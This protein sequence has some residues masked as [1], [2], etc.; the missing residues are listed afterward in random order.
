M[1]YIKGGRKQQAGYS[2][3]GGLTSRAP[4]FSGRLHLQMHDRGRL[5]LIL[6]DCFACADPDGAIAHLKEH[7]MYSLFCQVHILPLFVFENTSGDIAW[8]AS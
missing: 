6:M 3:G 4:I 7:C 8:Q 2:S 5:R 1:Q